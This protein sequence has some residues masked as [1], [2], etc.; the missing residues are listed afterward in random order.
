MGTG[1]GFNFSQKV[2]ALCIRVPLRPD[3]WD[4]IYYTT[5][6]YP[7]STHPSFSGRCSNQAIPNSS[8]PYNRKRK[9]LDFPDPTETQR[10]PCNRQPCS[11][12]RRAICVRRSRTPRADTARI[13]LGQGLGRVPIRRK[14][15]EPS[16]LP[17]KSRSTA[18]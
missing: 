1:T 13:H 12:L 6:I 8:S 4:V 9:N 11:H 18:R 16:L 7:V 5:I 3:M 14:K 17:S 10:P 2:R 15:G